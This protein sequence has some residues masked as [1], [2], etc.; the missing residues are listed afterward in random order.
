MAILCK[1]C[2]IAHDD[3]TLLARCGRCDTESRKPRL[4]PLLARMAS[5]SQRGGR[6]DP[7]CE[8]HPEEP[9]DIFCGTCKRPLSVRG[10]VGDRSVLAMMGDVG[11][12]KTWLLRVLS[13]RLREADGSAIFLRH[14]LGDTAEQ[15]AAV[16]EETRGSAGEPTPATDATVRNYA[17]EIMLAGSPRSWILAVHDAAGQVWNRL[18][19]LDRQAFDRLYRYLDIIGSVLVI[20]DGE[21]LAAILD[22]AAPA[23]AAAEDDAVEREIAMIDTIGRRI[24]ARG[25]A[26]PAAV[27]VSKIDVLW[28]L[29]DYA[30]FKPDSGAT[31]EDID[32]A[33]RTLLQK[34]G[35]N[36]L[37]AACAES[38]RPVRCFAVSAFG[39]V[40]Q[41]APSIDDVTPARIE[42]PL[43]ALLNEM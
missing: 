35:R 42:Q 18:H 23:R 41:P 2:W 1:D 32:A 33:V 24:Q 22:S 37:L 14:A 6:F 39:D 29:P 16:I 12:G 31:A 27:V 7:R 25:I 13:R 36:A 20:V 10:T 9:L 26:T 21:R 8:K 40:D 3:S 43:V 19:S 34:C 17:W 11:A 38:F 15:M 28:H 4:D 30:L 5:T